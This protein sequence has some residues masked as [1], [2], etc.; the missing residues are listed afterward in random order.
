M[1]YVDKAGLQRY[2]NGIKSKLNNNVKTVAQTL[3]AEEK[4]QAR[5]NINGGT[6]GEFA[7]KE[8]LDELEGKAVLTEAQTLTDAQKAQAR[9]NINAAAPDGYYGESGGVFNF[10]KNFLG[11]NTPKTIYKFYFGPTASQMSGQDWTADSISGQT[12][13]IEKIKGKTLVFN[14]LVRSYN[15]DTQF[16]ISKTAT[17]HGVSLHGTLS[18]DADSQ[19]IIAS[20]NIT[21]KRNGYEKYLVYANQPIPD[22]VKLAVG[23][24]RNAS[25]FGKQAWIWTAP[26]ADSDWVNGIVANFQPNQEVNIQDLIINVINL[27]Q[28]FGVGNEPATVEEFKAMFPLDYYAY[29]TGE[30]I[31]LNAT[32]LKTAGFNQLIALE[33]TNLCTINTDGFTLKYKSS[34][35]WDN[36]PFAKIKA[37]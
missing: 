36:R 13:T 37:I 7:S 28:M 24:Y 27:T 35:Q 2:H 33:N 11:K 8:A 19:V 5:K 32:G 22:S 34:A 23:G 29:N 1:G 21:F 30:L 17:A 26:S 3:T 18:G 10:S 25:Q 15:L 14:Q 20:Q 9:G 4:T 12:A 16:G 6:G 31:S